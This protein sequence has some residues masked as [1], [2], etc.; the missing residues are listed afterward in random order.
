MMSESNQSATLNAIKGERYFICR[1]GLSAKMPLCD[2][3]HKGSGIRPLCFEAKENSLLSV[4][5][6]LKSSD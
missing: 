2:G 3:K 6:I 1:C 4:E 5:E